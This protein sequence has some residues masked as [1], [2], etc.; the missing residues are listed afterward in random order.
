MIGSKDLESHGT[1]VAG[2]VAASRNNDK[3][4]NGVAKNVKIMA[5]R[6]VP[7]G[8]EHDKDVADDYLGADG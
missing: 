3:G 6:V 5:V 8:D 4:V 2:I 1:H 7:D